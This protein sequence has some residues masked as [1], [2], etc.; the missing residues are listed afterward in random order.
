MSHAG[1]DYMFTKPMHGT[2]DIA[3]TEGTV[4]MHPKAAA[5]RLDIYGNSQDGHGK[6]STGRDTVQLMTGAPYEIMYKHAIPVEDMWYVTVPSQKRNEVI[7][8]LKSKGIYMI[9]GI[10]LENF[11]LTSGMT[12]PTV[13]ESRWSSSALP[14]A[15]TV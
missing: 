10:P 11:I 12:I 3:S 8:R 7:E 4:V 15:I 6:R 14:P 5:R 9:N 13:D 1:S 2:G